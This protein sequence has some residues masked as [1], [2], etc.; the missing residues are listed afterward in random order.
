MRRRLT[1]AFSAVALSTALAAG[2]LQIASVH[3]AA[4]QTGELRDDNPANWPMYNRSFDGA[5]HSPLTEITKDNIRNLHVAWIHQ[6]GAITL[7]LME[8]PLVIDGIVYS[9]ASYNRVFAL[10]A[11]TG[12]EIWHHYPRLDDVVNEIFYS[13]YSRGLAV[14]HGRVYL[15]TIDGRAIALDQKTGK[16]LWKTQL[17][18]PRKCAG[19]NFTSPPVVAGDMLTFGPTGGDLADQGLIHGLDAATGKLAWTFETLKDDPRSWGGE[20]R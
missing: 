2:T 13:P 9:I 6:P 3:V 10:N 20:C 4:A 17:V 15:A 11:A 19:C 16:E 5:R 8:T 7:G 14:A 12:E 18:E 1:Y